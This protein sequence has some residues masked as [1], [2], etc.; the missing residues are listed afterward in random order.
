MSTLKETVYQKILG[1]IISRELP[2]GSRLPSELLLAKELGVSRVTLR[3]ALAK[4]QH[5]G[6]IIRSRQRGT[7]IKNPP[8][9]SKKILVI[10]KNSSDI[11]TDVMQIISGV[12]IVCNNY[13]LEIDTIGYEEFF[14]S[15]NLTEKYCGI[16]YTGCYFSGNEK[17][18]Q[19]LK[20]CSIP[21]VN[22]LSFERD[23]A[24][25]GHATILTDSLSAWIDGIKHLYN[26]GHRNIG[27]L[28]NF[29]SV[30][31]ARFNCE[32]DEFVKISTQ[33]F[34]ESHNSILFPEQD[35]H[36][37]NGISRLLNSQSPPTALYCYKTVYALDVYQIA[38]THKKI[39]PQDLAVLGFS[40]S[41]SALLFNPPLSTIDFCYQRLG[42]IAAKVLLDHKIWEKSPH[43]PVITVPYSVAVRKSTDHFLWHY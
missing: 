27:F 17:L 33:Y 19:M 6:I 20:K 30:I 3:G 41:T 2:I 22:C 1:K 12:S 11:E 32:F 39:I 37:Y 7:I 4:L 14:S 24:I 34:P 28:L 15:L 40:G 16:I 5:E 29:Q 36:F 9:Q 42:R 23:C 13:G 26:L 10:I 18:L 31:S 25:T 8:F 38:K 21:I 43:N 35:G